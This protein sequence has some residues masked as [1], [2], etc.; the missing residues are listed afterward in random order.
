MPLFRKKITNQPRQVRN[1]TAKRSNVTTYYRA[2]SQ[3]AASPFAKETS[4]K[5]VRRYVF[6]VLDILLLIAG[7]A[8]LL[9]SLMINSSVKVVASSSAYHDKSLYRSAAS[10]Q[11]GRLNNRNKI[12]FNQQA[13]AQALQHQFPEIMA[14]QTELPLFSERPTVRLAI[15][16]PNF[17]LSSQGHEYVVSA[18]GRNVDLVKDLPQIKG[19]ITIQDQSGYQTTVGQQVL[20][21]NSVKFI[22]T[23]IAECH[24]SGIPVKSL[25]LPK[26]PQE[27][28]LRTKDQPY[29]V[30]FYLDGDPLVESGQFLAARAHFKENN[31]SPSQYLDVRVT[32]KI[33]YQ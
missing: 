7:I 26:N 24:R 23:V 28:D 22:N 14:V 2:E 13:M 6:G 9:Y 21:S 4:K 30:K 17:F 31:Q 5:P 3:P 18:D 12:T 15:A 25:T 10:A 11:L 16:Q 29:Y 32:G 8:A 33:F 20:S 27:L 19:L 1:Q